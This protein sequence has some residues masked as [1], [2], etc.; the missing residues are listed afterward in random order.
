MVP[1]P[2]SP[3]ATSPR[4]SQTSSRSPTPISCRHWS[5][6]CPSGGPRDHRLEGSRAARLPPVRCR[7]PP[8]GRPRRLGAR[9][10]RRRH[11]PVRDRDETHHPLPAPQ[12]VDRPGPPQRQG[13]RP[14]VAAG[15]RPAQRP[16]ADRRRRRVLARRGVPTGRAAARARDRAVTPFIADRDFSLYVGDVRAVLAE[17]EDE[18]VHCV[19]TSPPY[20]GLR[21]YGTGS[22]AGGNENCDHKTRPEYGRAGK[23]FK[24]YGAEAGYAP[25][26][27]FANHKALDQ[28]ESY[29]ETCGKCGATRT[30]QQ[31]GLEKTP[32]EYVE[33]MVAVFR[34]VRRVLRRDGTC[35]LNIGDSY[36][37]GTSSDRIKHTTKDQND[38]RAKQF[39]ER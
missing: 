19:V 17:L 22:W 11:R 25:G 24:D 36:N 31:L 39:A 29:K 30:D 18:S 14:P 3:S 37:A 5:S 10:R 1:P 20:W 2:R 33:N 23:T 15:D 27:N 21:D 35:W 6:E 26:S 9:V 12:R 38:T 7:A 16:P 4:S 32:D 28:G 34:Q 13:H 8:V